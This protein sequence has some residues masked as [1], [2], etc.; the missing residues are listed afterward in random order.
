MS[1][2]NTWEFEYVDEQVQLQTR[3]ACQGSDQ[4]HKATLYSNVNDKG[5]RRS[6]ILQIKLQ[7]TSECDIV[8]EC[9]IAIA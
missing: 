3:K 9:D 4:A 7:D 2:N 1:L 5:K 8:V 6:Y